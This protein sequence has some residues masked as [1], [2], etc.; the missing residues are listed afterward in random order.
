MAHRPCSQHWS[1]RC[2]SRSEAD[3]SLSLAQRQVV[4]PKEGRGTHH[5]ERG[6]EGILGGIMCEI[7][8]ERAAALGA[9]LS[10]M[11]GWLAWG[12][13][14]VPQGGR[15]LV[16]VLL[17][18]TRTLPHLLASAQPYYKQHLCSLI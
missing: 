4:L 14:W 8:P 9:P 13:S 7:P 3:S 10:M 5:E 17:G 1:C 6:P 16:E 15:A 11:P 2:A 12:Y 18:H